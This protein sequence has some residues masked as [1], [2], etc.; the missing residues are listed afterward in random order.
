MFLLNDDFEN[1]RKDKL[2]LLKKEKNGEMVVSQVYI[3]DKIIGSIKYGL[4]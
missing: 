4:A 2:S 1:G 3:D